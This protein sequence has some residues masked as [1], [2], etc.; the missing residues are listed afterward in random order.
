MKQFVL[1]L[2]PNPDNESPVRNLVIENENGK[3]QVLCTSSKEDFEERG[4]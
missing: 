4:V 2:N 1:K 3:L